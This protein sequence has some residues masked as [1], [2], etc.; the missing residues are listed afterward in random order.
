MK[1]WLMA[2][3][4]SVV[5][6]AC[7]G[8]EEDT[9]KQLSTEDLDEVIDEGTVG[10]EI[11]DGDIEEAT[12]VPEDEKK[13]IINAFEEYMNSFN[14]KDIERYKQTISKDATGF[15][16][17]TEITEV[18]KVFNQYSTIKRSAEDVTIVKYSNE[19][20]QVFSNMKAEMI[21]KDTDIPLVGEARTVVV[22]VKEGDAWK[23]SSVH[24]MSN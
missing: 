22:F 23:V 10:F 14:D 3:F 4:A 6:A 7:G 19:E 2:L 13:K 12:G 16:Y 20:A 21:E 8:N 1:K 9:T 17:E 15:D 24:S 5:L 11:I 18:E